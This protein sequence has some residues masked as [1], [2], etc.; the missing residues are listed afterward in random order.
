M[1]DAELEQI[2]FSVLAQPIG[3]EVLTNS[4]EDLKR[5]LYQVRSKAKKAGIDT[6]DLLTFRTSPTNSEGSLW[7]IKKKPEQ[8]PTKEPANASA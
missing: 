8:E 4:P 3:L 2:L 6:F 5:R 1:T 7:I